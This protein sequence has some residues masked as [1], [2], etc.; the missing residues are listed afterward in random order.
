MEEVFDSFMDQNE[1]LKECKTLNEIKEEIQNSTRDQT[2]KKVRCE[3]KD[4]VANKNGRFP[5]KYC[6]QTFSKNKYLMSHE[7]KSCKR[8]SKQTTNKIR[9][10]IFDPFMDQ[11]VNQIEFERSINK[12]EEIISRKK[13]SFPCRMCDKNSV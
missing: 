2:K 13:G 8:K 7:K 3:I 11:A 1:D 5:C 4:K 6:N 9:E 10:E 12:K